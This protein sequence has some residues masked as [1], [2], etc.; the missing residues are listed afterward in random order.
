I[1]LASGEVTALAEGTDFCSSPRP[2]PD[3][4]RLCWLRWNHPNLPWDGTEL[5]VADVGEDGLPVDPR[6]VAGGPSDWIAQPRWSPSGVLHFAA[7]PDGWMNLFRLAADDRIE[8]VTD[9][10]EAEFAYPDWVFGIANFA[11][12]D[13]GS[14]VAVARSGGRDRLHR[15]GVDGRS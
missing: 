15:I 11:F 7:E 2:S 4:R 10:I 6:V 8:R 5:V 3:G 1:D 12:A 14:I 9:P 13:D